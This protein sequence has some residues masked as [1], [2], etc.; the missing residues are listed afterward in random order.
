MEDAPTPRNVTALTVFVAFLRQ[1]L[2]AFGGPTAHLAYF[3]AE[4]VER[5]RWLSEAAFADL[6][7]LCHVLP[8]QASSQLGI[9]IGL[10][11]AGVSGALAAFAGFTLPAAVAMIALARLAP[12]LTVHLGPGWLHGLQVAAAAVV[13]QA[14]IQMARTLAVGPVRAGLAIGAALGLIIA[15]GPVAHLMVLAAGGAFGMALLRE[16]D[17]D[18]PRDDQ[19]PVV[20]TGSANVALGLFALLL[21]GLPI[22]A[23]LL[24]NPGLGMA[25]VFYRTGAMVFGGGHVVMPLLEREVV[26]RGWLDAQTFVAGYGLLQALP[27]PLFG[28]AG[29]VGAAQTYGPGGIV[30][31]LIALL[32]I[33]M[34]GLLL[35][36]GVMPHWDR[37]K[38]NGWARGVSA[39]LG[40]AVVGLLAAAL[41]DPVLMIAVR[42]PAD[43]ALVAAAYVFLAIAR[44]PPWM[45]VIGFAVATAVF[46]P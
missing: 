10:R 28:F 3:R 13:L 44:A 33:S 6:L 30:G 41:W 37:L 5:R 38:H 22:A 20:D 34:P 45:V 12:L 11:M 36:V 14:V 27:G 9:A 1:G 15:Q 25:G 18:P 26:E 24:A 17:P 21:V 32:A 23:S 7:A 29:Y 4:F 42:R 35:V 46:L 19:P 16:T 43:W 31:G 40:A 8:G 39:G 2:T